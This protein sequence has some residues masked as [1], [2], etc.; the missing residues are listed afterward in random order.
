MKR[1]LCLMLAAILLGLSL[2]ACTRDVF[3]KKLGPSELYTKSEINDA[4]RV[5]MR[6]FNHWDDG[7]CRM[8]E[9]KYAGDAVSKENLAYCNSF[10]DGDHYDSCIV[11]ITAFRTPAKTAALNPNEFYTGYTWTLARSGAGQWKVV[12]CGYG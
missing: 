6:D 11:F 7:G 4:V 1:T 8:I 2:S 3:M 5:L 10:A 12:T 9:V